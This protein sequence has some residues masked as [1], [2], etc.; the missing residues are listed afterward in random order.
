MYWDE[1]NSLIANNNAWFNRVATHPYSIGYDLNHE[2]GHTRELV[3]DNLS[4][5][6][7]EYKIDG[8]RFDLAKGFTQNN[9]GDDIGAWSAYDQSRV[10]II[11]DY[12]NH[13]KSVNAN[14][15]FILE[16]FADN[17]EE[18]VLANNG[19]M[20]W[21]VMTEQ[22]SQA[23]MGYQSNSDFSAAYFGGEGGRA[24]N[25]PNLI[26]FMESHDEERQMFQNINY[27]AYGADNLETSLRYSKAAA[28]FYMAIPGP[29]MIWQLEEL[30]YDEGIQLC[31]DGT[32]TE[33]CRTAAKPIH[34]EYRDEP[35]RKELYNYYS[36]MARLKKGY[37]TFREGSYTRDFS[38]S[39][40]RM[41]LAHS[42]MN[43][44]V[45]GNF[46]T[47]AFDMTPGFQHTGTWYDFFTGQSVE[48]SDAGGHTVNF[49]PGDVHL[50]TDV[51]VGIVKTEGADNEND[52]SIHPNPASDFIHIELNDKFNYIVTD[53]T[54]KQILSG[55]LQKGTNE[56][57]I[58]DLNQTLYII[59]LYN[60]KT[61]ISKKIN[62]K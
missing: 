54:G 10:D 27:A 43:V 48:I 5:W 2:S 47:T 55:Q 40:K 57:N 6:M 12:Y 42:D 56:L 34:W 50:W 61:N 15:N 59:H 21:G 51:P 11:M 25:Y 46:G 7:T 44:V 60:D 29:K 30:G 37:A 49:Q 52:I 22:F 16:H 17:S 38:G 3:K 31:P 53:I 58:S 41:W 1:S 4:Y 20:L 19:C 32:Y 23:T 28:T 26:P 24:W 33:D 8:F 14:A 13:V 9:T 36:W 62:V 39:G 18:T 35:L 45:A